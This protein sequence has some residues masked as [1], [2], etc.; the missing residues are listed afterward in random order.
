MKAILI[1]SAVLCL[2][3]NSFGQQQ[4][5]DITYY[6][7]YNLSHDPTLCATHISEYQNV[8]ISNSFIGD[9]VKF[10]N[11]SG[12]VIHQEINTSGAVNWQVYFPYPTG[13]TVPDYFINNGI[14]SW[15]GNNQINKIISDVDTLYV[16][17]GISESVQNWGITPCNY[18]T[19]SGM[20]YIDYDNNC[21]FSGNDVGVTYLHPTIIANYT[22][23]PY[24]ESYNYA[25]NNGNYQKVV[26][27]SWLI[28]YAVSIPSVYQFAF[29]PSP[30]FSTSYTFTSLPQ[31]NVDF[32]LQCADLDTRVHGYGTVA[33]P[34]IPFYL[35]PRVYNIGCTAVSGQLKLKLDPNVTYNP[36]NSSNPADAVNGDTL[37][38]NYANLN[39]LYNNSL[40]TNQ[41]ISGIELT[42]NL[43]VNIGD[44]LLFELYTDLHPDDVNPSNNVYHFSV[45]IVNSYDPNNKEVEPKGEGEEGFIPATTEKLTYTIHFQ[46]T[47]TAE[48]ININI[49]DTLE[50]TLLPTTL[51]IL[52]VSHSVVP[53]WLNNHTIRFRFPNIHLPDSTSNEPQ[54]HGFVRF[55]VGLAQ[56]LAP[57][58]EIK[59][60]VEI[61]FDTNEPIV[62]NHAVNTI[63]FPEEDNLSVNGLTAEGIKV[64]PNPADDIVNFQLNIPASGE[65]A[66]KD[67]TGKTVLKSTY[68]NAQLIQLDTKTLTNGIYVYELTE[69]TGI[70]RTGKLIVK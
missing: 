47:G 25:N 53:E 39:N 38:W 19:I 49:I 51:R 43:N 59:N 1:F 50:A 3:L 65:L 31:A 46:N 45:P 42:P 32:P 23:Q 11:Y 41:F 22:N 62:T 27:E 36:A 10:I 35:H 55:E 30:C 28:D 48:A 69:H 54:S 9:T 13:E 60:K 64:Y 57:G 26:Q 24:S 14:L 2:Y 61:Y 20:L 70:T 33:R 63:E 8:T 34:A 5:G 4:Q 6:Y 17:A 37:I 44:V 15:W 16:P 58:T 52:E 56:H 29:Q 7:G 18:G 68:I 21:S 40:Y 66:I 67:I 12:T